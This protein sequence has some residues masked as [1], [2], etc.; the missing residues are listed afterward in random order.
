[1]NKISTK[2]Y[3]Y[4][5]DKGEWEMTVGRERQQPGIQRFDWDDKNI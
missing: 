4:S 1:M 2:L 5:N 3:Q